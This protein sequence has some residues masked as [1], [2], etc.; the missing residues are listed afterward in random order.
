MKW[1]SRRTGT[2]AALAAVLA[3][4]AFGT[5]CAAMADPE[6]S[7]LPWTDSHGWEHSPNLPSSML[8][9]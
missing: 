7:E 8:N 5:G 1:C 2:A 3:L 9:N 4:L 6:G